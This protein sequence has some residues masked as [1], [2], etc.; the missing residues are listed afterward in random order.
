MNK[1]SFLREFIDEKWNNLRFGK[2]EQYVHSAY[3]IHLD[4]RI[5]ISS[6][7]GNY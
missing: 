2:V 7:D 5:K 6:D 4:T 1:E 3:T